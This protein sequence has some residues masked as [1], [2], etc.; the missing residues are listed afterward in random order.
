ADYEPLYRHITGQPLVVPP[1][2]G[3]MRKLDT[4]PD[5]AASA[6]TDT[7]KA[8]PLPSLPAHDLVNPPTVTIDRL[9]TVKGD[10]FG[11]EQELKL[12]DDAL[13]GIEKPLSP[14][15]RGWG[16]GERPKQVRILQFIASGGTGKTKLLRHWL[17]QNEAQL[18]NHIVWSFYSQGS[19]EDKQVT[20]S[21]MF[22][23]ALKA[24]GLD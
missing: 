20:S 24:Y 7:A 13:A 19:S 17:N 5:P 15:E 23:E 3:E 4:A 16:E 1:E 8:A 18:P 9:P 12:L 6:N 11:R 21:P 2:L 10:F 22:S 14:R